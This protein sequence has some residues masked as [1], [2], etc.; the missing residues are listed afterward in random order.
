MLKS[1]NQ[2]LAHSLLG[3]RCKEG[4]V[5][6][7]RSISICEWADLGEKENRGSLETVRQHSCCRCFH[8][9]SLRASPRLRVSLWAVADRP[10][11][12]LRSRWPLCSKQCTPGHGGTLWEQRKTS[13]LLCNQ[14]CI[15]T[16]VMSEEESL[17]MRVSVNGDDMGY[18]SGFLQSSAGTGT[19]ATDLGLYV[20][21]Y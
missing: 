18:Q 5:S 13:C 21:C 4:L 8:W 2:C 9:P 1:A 15:N 14:L 19:R 20:Q 3:D 16:D 11:T 17:L 10:L 6:K 12:S 7:M